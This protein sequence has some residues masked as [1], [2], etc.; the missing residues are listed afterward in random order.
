MLFLAIE[1]ILSSI[2]FIQIHVEMGDEISS[3]KFYSSKFA[4]TL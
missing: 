3:D 1:S 4:V 2:R